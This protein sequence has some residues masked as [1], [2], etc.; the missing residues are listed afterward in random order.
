MKKLIIILILISIP[1]FIYYK[2]EKS[3]PVPQLV[4]REEI[5]ITI[6]PGWDLRQ[7]ADDWQKKGL[8]KNKE[9]LYKIVGK[10]AYEYSGLLSKAPVL[11]FTDSAGKDMFPILATRPSSVS[12]EGYFF[13]D[14]YRVYKDSELSDVLKKIFSNLESK[15][16]KEMRLEINKQGKNVFQILNMAALIE[17]EANT[18]YDMQMISDIFWRRNKQKWALQSC[19]SVNYV[20]LKNT[21]AISTEDQKIDSPYNTYKYSGLPH[22][23]IGNP[24]I[25]AIKAAIYPKTNN[26]WYFMTGTDGKMRYAVTLDQHNENVFNYLK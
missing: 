10:P 3:K 2:R 22:G 24:G 26:Y 6:I 17:R 1:L 20:T 4:A 21:P 11:S 18:E 15:I 23:P 9:E 7:I 25:T 14:T 19:A 8:I 5:N 13:P 12:Y 16:T